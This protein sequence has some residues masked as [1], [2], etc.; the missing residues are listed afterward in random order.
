M[1]LSALADKI[2]IVFETLTK[3]CMLTIF[4]S[5]S[6]HWFQGIRN[7]PKLTVIPAFLSHCFPDIQLWWSTSTQVN[8][9]SKQWNTEEC[10]TFFSWHPRALCA[11]DYLLWGALMQACMWRKLFLDY[12]LLIRD[13]SWGCFSGYSDL[14]SPLS[15]GCSLLRRRSFCSS[16]NPSQ[17]SLLRRAI[18]NVDQSQHTSRSGKCTLD[19]KKFSARRETPEHR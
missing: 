10:L 11:L 13:R 8:N 6:S 19:L 3:N 15:N 4:L 9:K 17:R 7:L 5:L 2:R 1:G 16:R 18:K 12:P 14:E